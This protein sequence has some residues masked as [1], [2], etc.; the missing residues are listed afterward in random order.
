M[1][2]IIATIL[3]WLV[4]VVS[5]TAHDSR[6]LF[7]E[8]NEIAD[9]QVELTWTAPA[10]VDA[11]NAPRLALAEPCLERRRAGADRARAVRQTRREAEVHEREQ[12]AQRE[13][14]DERKCEP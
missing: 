8:L 11:G 2:A 9:G 14:D 7:V 1:R 6:P 5:A 10:T 13:A 3:L 4:G 12:V